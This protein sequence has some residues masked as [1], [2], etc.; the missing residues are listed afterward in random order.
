MGHKA[1]LNLGDYAVYALAELRGEPVLATGADF[2]ATW[3]PAAAGP[4]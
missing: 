4:P 2:A 1:Q 3:L